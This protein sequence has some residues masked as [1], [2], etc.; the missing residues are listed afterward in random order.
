MR[1]GLS[2]ALAWQLYDCADSAFVTTVVAAVLPVYFASVVCTA[3]EVAF[4]IGPLSVGGS[5]TSLW[6]YAVALAAAVV[7]A[8]SPAAG[9]LADATGR[10]K[11]LLACFAS[12]GVAS[13]AMLSFSGPGMVLYTLAFLVLG[14]IGFAG[15]Q[16]FYNALLMSVAPPSKRDS[17]SA[18]GFAAGYL[19]GG[20]LLL[21]N[22]MMIS[23]PGMFGL[24]D[25]A[26]ASR[27]SFATVAAWWALLSVPL[28]VFVREDRTSASGF[29]EGMRRARGMLR[30]TMRDILRRRNLLTFLV[31]FLLYNDGIQTVILM[32]TVYG[33]A[34][35][36]LETGDLILA[37]LVTQAVGVPGSW[38]YGRA[39]TRI[40][41][42]RAILVGIGAYILIV[43][44][45][46]RMNS[47]AE[48]TAL[49]ALVGLVQG[50]LQAVSRS[51]FSR[52][53]PAGMGAEYFGFFSVSTRFASIFGP[54]LFALVRDL[55]GSGRSAIL[56][57][58]VLFLLGGGLMLRV[59]EPEEA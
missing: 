2:P 50:G 53:V 7:A 14:D 44:W 12:L 5:P 58:I 55:T 32:A 18:G 40:G 51:F 36:G 13:A 56:A 27:A 15:G 28:L 47:A 43:L 20:L 24:A 23:K 25:A 22:V 38:L 17:V 54:L 34:D 46:F 37:L 6:G 52:L 41:A 3:G 9:A 26:A 31:A 11:L 1:R 57:V 4:S 19:G 49:A 48:F 8:V 45:A 59:R 30:S 10:K 16:V 21:V 35:L 33:R 29:A 39:A 42:R